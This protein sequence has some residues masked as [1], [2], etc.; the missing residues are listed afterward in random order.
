MKLRVLVDNQSLIDRY[1]LAEPALALLVEHGGAR[2]LF[3]AGYSDAFARNAEAM[4]EDLA[5]LDWVALSHGHLDHTWGLDALIRVQLSAAECG[6]RVPRPRLVAHPGVFDSRSADGLPEI[7]ALLTW[8]KAARHFDT[9]PEPGPRELAPGLFFLGEIPRLL[10]FEPAAPLG[11]R[12]DG[13]PDFLP[14]DTALACVV[15]GGL[16]V[17]TGC[18]HAGVCNTVAHAMAV[19]GED[20]VRAVVGGMH[21]LAAPAKRLRATAQYLAALRPEALYPC[22]CTDFAARLALARTCPVRE[23]GVGSVLEFR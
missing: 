9:M 23:I 8:D 12:E 20:R 4:G 18:A 1:F 14:D 19:T 13:S 2:V 16:V 6:R 5:H 17:V 7:G 15:D 22:H 21:L 11:L 10:D 3:D